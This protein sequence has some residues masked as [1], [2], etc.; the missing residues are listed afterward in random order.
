VD[1]DA[2]GKGGLREASSR[3]NV[4]VHDAIQNF[5]DAGADVNEVY[6]EILSY[7][8]PRLRQGPD[9]LGRVEVGGGPERVR[10]RRRRLS[11][12][13]VTGGLRCRRGNWALEEGGESGGAVETSVLLVLVPLRSLSSAPVMS[14]PSPPRDLDCWSSK[15]RA[16]SAAATLSM[17]QRHAIFSMERRCR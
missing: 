3:G 6:P 8:V 16:S 5:I 14:A 9:V 15:L 4:D 12:C 2:D 13:F 11:R 10:Q 1:P 7:T 17:P